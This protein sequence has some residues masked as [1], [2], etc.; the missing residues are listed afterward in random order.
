M[1]LK[2]L[3]ILSLDPH[4][5]VCRNITQ[6][7]RSSTC[8]LQSLSASVVADA[9]VPTIYQ[10]VTPRCPGAHRPTAGHPRSASPRR[11]VASR[12]SVDIL[13]P[14]PIDPPRSNYPSVYCQMHL[15]MP[16]KVSFTTLSPGIKPRGGPGLPYTQHDSQPGEYRGGSVVLYCDVCCEF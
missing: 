13:Q 11:D 9:R 4:Y 1:L 16:A 8:I 10:L 2:S 7:N 15:A 6:D 14:S 12:S 5:I 3:L